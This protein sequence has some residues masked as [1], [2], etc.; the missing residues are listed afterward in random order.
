MKYF[1]EFLGFLGGFVIL[2]SAALIA[3]HFT[4][5]IS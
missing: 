2:I 1:I 5:P 3:I 4:G